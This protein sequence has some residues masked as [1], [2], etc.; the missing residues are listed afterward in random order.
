VT[1]LRPLEVVMQDVEGQ[2]HFAT[3][4]GSP[5]YAVGETPLPGDFPG[6]H[7]YKIQNEGA[8]DSLGLT[9]RPGAHVSRYVI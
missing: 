4:W 7:T 1:A 6:P 3:T 9:A 2:I 8:D 5:V